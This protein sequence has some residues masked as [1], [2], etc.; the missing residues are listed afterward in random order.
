MVENLLKPL[1]LKT[2]K[3]EKTMKIRRESETVQCSFEMWK[4]TVKALQTFSSGSAWTR[5]S[6][7][8]LL[9]CSSL[10]SLLGK[11]VLFH[12]QMNDLLNMMWFAVGYVISCTRATSP[13]DQWTL[14]FN[15]M[16]IL[17]CHFMYSTSTVF[18]LVTFQSLY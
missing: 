2:K 1:F 5:L 16:Q 15:V 17:Q 6:P 18:T 8:L 3:N 12:P 4:Y 14:C 13:H 10:I 7:G 11:S 9:I